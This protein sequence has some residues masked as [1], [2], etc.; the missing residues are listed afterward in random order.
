MTATSNGHLH[1]YSRAC[2]NFVRAYQISIHESLATFIVSRRCSNFQ[3]FSTIFHFLK[4]YQFI[5][6]NIQ[7]INHHINWVSPARQLC[8]HRLSTKRCV[9]TDGQMQGMSQ[10]T[11]ARRANQIHLHFEF[12]SNKACWKLVVADLYSKWRDFARSFSLSWL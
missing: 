8:I 12:V 10:R 4:S 9:S 11:S 1:K 3:T 6:I 7:F 5:F 2:S